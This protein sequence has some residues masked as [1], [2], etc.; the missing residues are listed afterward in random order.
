MVIVMSL[1]VSVGMAC[2]ALKG[3]HGRSCV[4]VECSVCERVSWCLILQCVS[5]P[6][7]TIRDTSAT[8]S[9]ET[10]FFFLPFL[11]LSAMISGSSPDGDGGD[12]VLTLF[13]K[14]LL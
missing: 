9:T 11:C 3:T 7:I 8:G 12:A 1:D 4:A 6:H 14:W 13:F 10:T 2:V 5:D